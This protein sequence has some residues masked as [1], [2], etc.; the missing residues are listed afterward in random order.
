ML[1]LLYY[2]IFNVRNSLK[3]LLVLTLRRTILITLNINSIK[4]Y[5]IYEIEI[6]SLKYRYF[7]FN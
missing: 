3:S 7:K 5:K 4:Y 6:Y 2:Y 1:L